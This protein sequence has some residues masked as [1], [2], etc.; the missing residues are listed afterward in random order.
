MSYSNIKI[1]KTIQ[2][3]LRLVNNILRHQSTNLLE[4]EAEELENIF[5]LL[6]LGTIIGLPTAPTHLSLEL[7]PLMETDLIKMLD[8]VAMASGPVSDLFSNLEIG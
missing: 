6:V 2:E 4:W 7:L 5:S 8:K 3:K 1:I